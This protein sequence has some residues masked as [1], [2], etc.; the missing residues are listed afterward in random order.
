MD[1]S[2]AAKSFRRKNEIVWIVLGSVQYFADTP[3]PNGKIKDATN[4]QVASRSNCDNIYNYKL[5]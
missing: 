5:F 3:T 2:E 4:L 1:S